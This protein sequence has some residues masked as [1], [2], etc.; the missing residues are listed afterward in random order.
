MGGVCPDGGIHCGH[1]APERR[2]RL[3]M[4][5]HRWRDFQHLVAVVSQA[6]HESHENRCTGQP[7]EGHDPRQ[8]PGLA[9]EE[10]HFDGA[11]PVSV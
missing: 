8:E 6:V 5:R 7:G 3:A 10:G 1:A 11:G 9:P 4:H 2:R